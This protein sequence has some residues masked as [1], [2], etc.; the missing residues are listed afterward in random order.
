MKFILNSTQNHG[1][2]SGIFEFRG[3]EP[4]MTNSRLEAL[5]TGTFPP[6]LKVAKNWEPFPV[7]KN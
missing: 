2:R 3:N 6:F 5:T 4:T 1:H 7:L